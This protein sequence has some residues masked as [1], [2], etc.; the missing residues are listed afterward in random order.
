MSKQYRYRSEVYDS[1]FIM[2]FEE[3]NA[4]TQCWEII[5]PFVPQG[6]DLDIKFDE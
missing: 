5:D 6:I 2:V 1:E 3:L 4:A